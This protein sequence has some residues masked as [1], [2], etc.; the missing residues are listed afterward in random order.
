[1]SKRRIYWDPK[2]PDWL[3]DSMKMVREMGG[4]HVEPFRRDTGS[5]NGIGHYFNVF[6][7]GLRAR[8]VHDGADRR[9]FGDFDRWN[10]EQTRVDDEV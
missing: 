3:L 6:S 1:M 2:K 9:V 10:R 8:K 7:Y 4:L 5:R